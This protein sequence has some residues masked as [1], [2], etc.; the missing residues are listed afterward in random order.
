M[1]SQHPDEFR[2]DL[3]S[4][5]EA[6]G[7]ARRFVRAHSDSLPAAMLDDAQLLVSELVTNAVRHGRPAISLVVS[8]HPPLIGVA[9][10][11]EGDSLPPVAPVPPDAGESGGRGLMIVDRLSSAWGV[12]PDHQP[13]GKTVW[14]RIDPA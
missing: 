9:V 4:S 10:H 8:L 6:A 1:E 7:V 2:I 13:P 11:D 3:T 5:P 12:L 14:F